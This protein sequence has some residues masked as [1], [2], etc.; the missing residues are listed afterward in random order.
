MPHHAPGGVE[1]ALGK[2]EFFFLLATGKA[3]V[4][5]IPVEAA[6]AVVASSYGGLVI[7]RCCHMQDSRLS[8]HGLDARSGPFENRLADGWVG[9]NARGEVGGAGMRGLL[10]APAPP[11]P[12]VA[13]PPRRGKA[14]GQFTLLHGCL[15]TPPGFSFFITFPSPKLGIERAIC[16]L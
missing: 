10:V 16:D 1:Y 15:K 8:G 12:A 6:Y 11:P 2:D 7:S 4:Q 13:S 14:S 9:V 3:V 5:I